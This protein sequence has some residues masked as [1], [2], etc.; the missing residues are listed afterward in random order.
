MRKVLSYFFLLLSVIAFLFHPIIGPLFNL[1]DWRF[2]S[3]RVFELSSFLLS[4]SILFMPDSEF[5]LV[6]DS[7]RAR[8][9]R[10]ILLTGCLIINILSIIRV[11]PYLPD[12]PYWLKSDYCYVIG[13]PVDI[14]KISGKNVTYQKFKINGIEFTVSPPAVYK[15]VLPENFKITYLPHS[16]YVISVERVKEE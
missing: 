8:K 10:I 2:M 14:R 13:E 7:E 12:I 6:P 3:E 11:Y 16:K 9:G 5:S 4:F 15:E 1:H